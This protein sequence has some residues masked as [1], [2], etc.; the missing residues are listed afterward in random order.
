MYCVLCVVFA[1]CVIKIYY[2]PFM[3]VTVNAV[4][5]VPEKLITSC[6]GTILRSKN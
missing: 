4:I 5:I 3:I 1:E 6:L 2:L